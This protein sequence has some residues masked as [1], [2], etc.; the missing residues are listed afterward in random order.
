MDLPLTA[1]HL[2]AICIDHV[3]PT[4]TGAHVHTE[5][6]S[7]RNGDPRVRH[8]A[9]LPGRDGHVYLS[10][11]TEIDGAMT[12]PAD[13][14]G[15]ARGRAVLFQFL[16][17]TPP[18]VAD[19]AVLRPLDPAGLT[20]SEIAARADAAGLPVEIRRSDLADPRPGEPPVAAARL[21]GFTAGMEL[22]TV[23][24]ADVLW[25]APLR[26]WAPGAYADAGPEVLSAAL[27]TPYPIARMIFDGER[28]VQ[29][30]MPAALAEFVHGAALAALGRQLGTDDLPA[31]PGQWLGGYGDLLAAMA[32]PDS[33]AFVRVDSVS[34]ISSVFL[35][36]HDR[37]GLAFLDPATGSAASFPPMPAGIELHPVDATGDDLTTW[38][39]EAAPAPVPPVRAVNRSSRMHAVPLGDTGRTMDVI[40]TPNGRNARFLDETAAAAA[41]VDAPVIAL[42]NDRPGAAPSRRE[43]Y[44]LE[45]ML[46]QQQRNVLA[47]GATP[48]VVVRG[49]APA[50]FTALLEKYD[51]A[52]VRQG[53][54]GG[55]LG[56]NLDNPWTGRNADGTLA[57]SPSRTLTGD[58]LRSVGARPERVKPLAADDRVLDLVSTPLDDVA[59]I[60]AQLNSSLRGLAPQIRALGAQPD[61]FAA[62]EAILRIDGRE[63]AALSG[64]AFEY[65]GAKA[66]PERKQK[67]L[68][69]V[70]SLI[71]RE[72][73]A[74]GDGFADLIDLT[75]GPLDDGA[76]RAVLAAVQLGI[77]GGSLDAIKQMI[78][79][80]SVY[81]PQTGR[82]DWIRE[83]RG[84]MQRMPEHGA[85]FEQVAVF[86]ET[87]P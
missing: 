32:K 21:L 72:P 54:P 24:D 4:L 87:C 53:R 62:W 56:I 5:P 40:G 61:M 15:A 60:K 3:L 39:P 82:T 25:V 51:F 38:L 55:G 27:S 2:S 57:T 84:L 73:A 69:F 77:E 17:Q 81:L 7:A 75:R 52:V 13:A 8:L 26:H 49:D 28:G 85:L 58:L 19:R 68:S 64:A 29:L 30:G 78:Y 67:A 47:G 12:T 59:A 10:F 37:H 18:E 14:P 41:Q 42:A 11:G 23:A 6:I 86:V 66:E 50:A 46:L 63:D 83:L 9:T 35:A 71:G 22:T 16:R 31:R 33:R 36:V 74:R 65:L 44:D 80:H 34:G 76:S 48:I 1:N 45:F 70:P 79:Q 43:L 20:L